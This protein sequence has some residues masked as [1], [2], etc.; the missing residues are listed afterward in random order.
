MGDREDGD[1]H[2]QLEIAALRKEAIGIM[3]EEWRRHDQEGE[4]STVSHDS[5]SR[6]TKKEDD[7]NK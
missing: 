2:L 4:V 6:S 5:D 3:K 1:R 7:K